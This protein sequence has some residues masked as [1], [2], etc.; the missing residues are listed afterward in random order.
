MSFLRKL[1]RPS[2]Q[3]SL[4]AKLASAFLLATL[5]PFS[6]LA[7]AVHVL[8]FRFAQTIVMERNQYLAEHI[9]VHLEQMLSEK[10]AIL[11]FAAAGQLMR[12]SGGESQTVMLTTMV[13]LDPDL[14]IAITIDRDGKQIARSDGQ[15]AEPNLN[16]ADRPYFQS[17]LAT[18]QAAFSDTL[19]SRTTGILSIAIAQP[20]LDDQQEVTRMIVAVIDLHK[21]VDIIRNYE[22]PPH[23]LAFLVNSDGQILYHPQRH[24]GEDM[25][26]VMHLATM[27]DKR[28]GAVLF[29]YNGEELVAGFSQIM[30]SGWFFVIRQPVSEAL[31]DMNR[32]RDV[33]SLLLLFIVGLSVLVGMRTARSIALPIMD[34]ASM[35]EK[36]AGGELNASIWT[37][38]TAEICT[39]AASFN[40]M[41]DKIQQREADLREHEQRYRSMVENLNIG[42]YRKLEQG[43]TVDHYANPALVKIFGCTSTKDLLCPDFFKT[44][45]HQQ[46][47]CL[48]VDSVNNN[49][50]II[51]REIKIRRPD[52]EEIWCSCT[53]GKHFLPET[54][55][56]WIDAMIEDITERKLAREKLQQAHDQLELKVHERTLELENINQKLKEL[57]LQD[58]LTGLANRRYFDEYLSREWQRAMREQQPL[59]LLL[60][61]VDHFKLYNDAYGHIAGDE[62]LKQV[63]AVMKAAAKRATDLAAR[64]GGEE[65]VLI[66]PGIAQE[67]AMAMAYKMLTR[68]EEIGLEHK[69]SPVRPYVTFSIGCAT[70]VP[71]MH[72]SPESILLAADQA[73][74]LAKQL[75]RN[76]VQC[77]VLPDQST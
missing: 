21:I 25:T 17:V 14:L 68:I 24:I 44:M 37:C 29:K 33:I 11:R 42:V 4:R 49:E 63:A 75:G 8:G 76:Q 16:Y 20:V 77:H 52:G 48:F 73:L 23:S 50:Q 19:V 26:D 71:V 2:H 45:L 6:I 67:Q 58:G 36:L 22:L 38:D 60:L 13:K 10:A 46:D 57:S 39:L 69:N 54:G 65:F 34:M 12:S 61:D 62:C 7:L 15:L 70:F 40:N 9:G 59:S 1:L 56:T 3:Q 41:A 27:R 64:Y 72:S 66:L 32:L 30:P 28:D 47:F 35:T 53:A 31:K 5:A 43:G 18:K 74:Y 51:N 55:Q